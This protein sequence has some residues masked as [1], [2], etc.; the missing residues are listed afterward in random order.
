MCLAVPAE[1]IK[2]ENDVATCKVGEGDT[3]VNASLMIM[4]EEVEIGD[5]LIIHAGFGI[6]KLDRAEAEETIRT[7]REV[8]QAAKDAGVDQDI[9]FD[10]PTI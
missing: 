7:L 5:Y 1:I 3:T 10:A 8:I 4:S 6:R 2:I 9:D